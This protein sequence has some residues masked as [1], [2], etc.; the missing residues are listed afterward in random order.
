MTDHQGHPPAGDV[1]T[2]ALQA[3]DLPETLA[4]RLPSIRRPAASGWRLGGR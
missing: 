3:L 2:T 1:G 4:T